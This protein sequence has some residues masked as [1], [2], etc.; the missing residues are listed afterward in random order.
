MSPP[1]VGDVCNTMQ[2]ILRRGKILILSMWSQ[3]ED[4]ERD[5]HASKHC[6]N[7]FEAIVL[8][9]RSFL[10][11]YKILQLWYFTFLLLLQPEKNYY[12]LL[13]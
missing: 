1:T 11:K 6:L 5:K 7:K 4:R 9:S 12:E 3:E 10:Y 8:I 2:V 13:P